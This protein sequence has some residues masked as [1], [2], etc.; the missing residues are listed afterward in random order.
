MS[1]G[2][3]FA[4]AEISEPFQHAVAL[5]KENVP[6]ALEAAVALM[7]E[8]CDTAEARPFHSAVHPAG[9]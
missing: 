8:V 3:W 9:A 2:A 6:G 4:V 1:Q 5:V 7:Q